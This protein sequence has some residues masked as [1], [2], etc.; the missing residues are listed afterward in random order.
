MAIS[1]PTSGPVRIRGSPSAHHA[2]GKSDFFFFT[3][4]LGF[5]IWQLTEISN[6]EKYLQYA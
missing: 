2:Q 5:G 1:K 4:I 6:G 3:I